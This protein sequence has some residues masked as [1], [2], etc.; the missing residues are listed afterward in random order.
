MKTESAKQG[1]GMG[2]ENN[3]PVKRKRGRDMGRQTTVCIIANCSLKI[4]IVLTARL[5]QHCTQ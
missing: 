4:K 2:W 1:R 3:S 5:K